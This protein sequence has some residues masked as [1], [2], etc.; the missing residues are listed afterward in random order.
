MRSLI[1]IGTL[2][3][4]LVLAKKTDRWTR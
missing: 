1:D 2:K 4:V 3:T